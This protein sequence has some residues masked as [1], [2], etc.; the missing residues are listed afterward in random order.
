MSTKQ[1]YI[2]IFI[3]VGDTSSKTICLQN[4]LYFTES[5]L[6]TATKHVAGILKWCKATIFRTIF[7]KSNLILFS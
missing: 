1:Y 6:K 7:L 2:Q 3:M 5:D 4:T